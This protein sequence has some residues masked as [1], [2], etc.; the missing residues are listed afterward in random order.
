MLEPQ[1]LALLAGRF[2][3]EED[4][5]TATEYAIL[6]ALLILV[7]VAAIGGIGGRVINL[8]TAID[9]SLPEGF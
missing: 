2:S 7:C 4:G 1:Q 3:R 9:A 8:Y 6:L 5:P